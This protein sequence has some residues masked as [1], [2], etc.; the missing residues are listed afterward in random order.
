MTGL[1]QVTGA[2]GPTPTV[3]HMRRR[4][5]LDLLYVQQASFWFDL[6]ILVLTAREV[7][8]SP[9]RNEVF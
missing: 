4:I 3:D 7:F 5:D 8:F 9:T 1:S 2:R 6:T